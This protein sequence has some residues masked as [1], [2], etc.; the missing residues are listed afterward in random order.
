MARFLSARA[1]RAFFLEA[2]LAQ[3]EAG[4]AEAGEAR[5]EQVG[6]DEGGEGQEPLADEERAALDAEREREHHKKA[7]HDADGT[8]DGHG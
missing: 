1:D 6:A 3:Q 8:F 4:R 2:Q 7:R 5:L